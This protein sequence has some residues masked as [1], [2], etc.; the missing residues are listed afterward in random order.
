MMT[1]LQDVLAAG[2]CCMDERH[3]QHVWLISTQHDDVSQ[4]ENP[5]PAANVSAQACHGALGSPLTA[6]AKQG[7][8][9]ALSLV[10][11]H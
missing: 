11:H 10:S 7:M 1:L 3:F 9:S 5:G 4:D 2:S 6:S 8:L